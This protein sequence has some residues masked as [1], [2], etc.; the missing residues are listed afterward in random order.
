MFR[1]RREFTRN[2]DC[3]ITGPKMCTLS[4]AHS[5]RKVFQDGTK[6]G[7]LKPL[8]KELDTDVNLPEKFEII[9]RIG[10]GKSGAYILVVKNKG[11]KDS[12][13]LFLKLYSDAVDSDGT[14]LNERPYR[15]IYTYCMLNGRPGFACTACFGASLWPH[16][17]ERTPKR[18]TEV[19]RTSWG[20][21][22]DSGWVFDARMLPEKR[23]KKVLWILMERAPGVT[24]MD[25][26]INELMESD[27]WSLFGSAL[28]IVS[29]WQTMGDRLGKNFTHWDFHPENIFIDS[30]QS[31]RDS[32]S[33][34]IGGIEGTLSFPKVTVIDFDLVT[35]DIFPTLLPEHENKI[36]S[37]LGITE[38]AIQWVMKWAPAGLMIH[39][40]SFLVL[41]RKVVRLPLNEDMWHILTYVWILGSY[42]YAGITGVEPEVIMTKVMR[43]LIEGGVD[44][45]LS[46]P[47]YL[48]QLFYD[49]Q[50]VEGQEEGIFKGQLEGPKTSKLLP[51][52]YS[53]NNTQPP[54]LLPPS[55]AKTFS[56]AS[57]GA[58]VFD[59][60][61]KVASLSAT[62]TFYIVAFMTLAEIV[63]AGLSNFGMLDTENL[64][65]NGEDGKVE[66]LSLTSTVTFL[67][68][69]A[70]RN[71]SKLGGKLPL[72]F[73]DDALNGLIIVNE[74]DRVSI[75][76]HYGADVSNNAD[77]FHT[78]TGHYPMLDNIALN[79]AFDTDIPPLLTNYRYIAADIWIKDASLG[80]TLYFAPPSDLQI[81]ITTDKAMPLVVGKLGLKV[82][83]KLNTSGVATALGRGL[84]KA[85]G[86]TSSE[87][88]LD[89]SKIMLGITDTAPP[90][91]DTISLTIEEFEFNMDKRVLTLKAS[92]EM[93]AESTWSVVGT[94]LSLVTPKTPVDFMKLSAAVIV[95]G[96][97]KI[98]SGLLYTFG[99]GIGI[100]E[101]MILMENVNGQ[102]HVQVNIPEDVIKPNSLFTCIGATTKALGGEVYLPYVLDCMSITKGYFENPRDDPDMEQLQLQAQTILRIIHPLH[103]GLVFHTEVKVDGKKQR[104]VIGDSIEIFRL[105]PASK[106]VDDQESFIL[107]PEI[108][109][110]QLGGEESPSAEIK[111]LT[112]SET[113]E[114]SWRDVTGMN[115]IVTSQMTPRLP[116][117][118]T[119]GNSQTLGSSEL[120]TLTQMPPRL[121]PRLPTRITT[122]IGGN[123]ESWKQPILTQGT[124]MRGQ[125][126]RARDQEIKSRGIIQQR[127]KR[128]REME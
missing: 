124:E 9:Q 52:E 40:F 51:P 39:W 85:I 106:M 94:F 112:G 123:E 1:H 14:V 107:E 20:P 34:N 118:I 31:R 113:P 96:V 127:T 26:P 44:V 114:E 128:G 6:Y 81:L 59:T 21:G 68:N 82:E 119:S 102:L 97:V 55:L 98:L 64:H 50:T 77:E 27:P 76:E 73:N 83:A 115:P 125:L 63:M 3:L 79:I 100:N 49:F 12:K 75:I 10:G 30:S 126:K 22:T 43:G 109:G 13:P 57:I 67:L 104:K 86:V 72:Q 92:S 11:D 53:T 36:G 24:L 15:E 117:I 58:V 32:F 8:W 28:E 95:K 48:F 23:P 16:D 99:I 88:S 54:Y 70:E 71:I 47:A 120:D 33:M 91:Q 90:P 116:P 65:K 61:D 101:N 89:F 45:V 38:R 35:S 42:A 74:K 29:V 84:A 111:T 122:G 56:E 62:G 19:T 18:P 2:K 69:E 37:P 103:L 93:F 41:M 25:L 7:R 5:C 78:A 46:S 66:N 110:L 108:L 121:P 17:W 60:L 4:D 80:A 87:T 105:T